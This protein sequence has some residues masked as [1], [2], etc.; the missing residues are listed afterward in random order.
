MSMDRYRV[1]RLLFYLFR[2]DPTSVT[3]TRAESLIQAAKILTAVEWRM[4][5]REVDRR[6]A[7]QWMHD[8]TNDKYTIE[9]LCM[10]I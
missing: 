8:L 4:D 2:A 3:K 1:I 7:F 9:E 6:L 10:A 5:P